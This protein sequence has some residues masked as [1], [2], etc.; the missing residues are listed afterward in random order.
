MVK[1]SSVS[2]VR[3]AA[4]STPGGV[5]STC[6]LTSA[7][8]STNATSCKASA[9]R[10]YV[11]KAGAEGEVLAMN[12]LGDGSAASPAVAGGR[13]YLKGRRFLYCVG[14]K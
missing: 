2:A 10:T 5:S 7:A 6:R 11:V 9:G 14:A 1:S 8:G 12:E 13:I 4:V 3:G